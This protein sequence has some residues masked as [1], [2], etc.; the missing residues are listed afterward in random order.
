[1]R[2]YLVRVGIDQAFDKWN[3]PSVRTQEMR[4]ILP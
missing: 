2:A 3:A 4:R 1:M